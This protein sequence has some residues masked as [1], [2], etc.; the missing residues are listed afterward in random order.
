MQDGLET[1]VSRK[2]SAAGCCYIRIGFPPLDSCHGRELGHLMHAQL[3]S[4]HVLK[5]SRAC[6]EGP[7]L[8]IIFNPEQGS[9]HGEVE[10]CQTSLAQASAS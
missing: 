5:A 8:L 10:R 9:G 1:R 6:G 3:G 4:T 7:R 2:A